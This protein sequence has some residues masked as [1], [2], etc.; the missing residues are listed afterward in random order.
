MPETPS[1]R[2][3]RNLVTSDPINAEEPVTMAILIGSLR[4]M[5]GAMTAMNPTLPRTSL[6]HHG[7][8]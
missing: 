8:E 4:V 7:S 5:K 1:P 3:A 2:P 6:V